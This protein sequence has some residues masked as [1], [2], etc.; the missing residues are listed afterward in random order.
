MVDATRAVVVF[1]G[2]A[3]L[4]TPPISARSTGI[5]GR[6]E[7]VETP[8]GLGGAIDVAVDVTA[9]TTGNR[10]RDEWFAALDPFGATRFPVAAYRSTRVEWNDGRGRVEGTLTLRGVTRPVPLTASYVL[11]RGGGHMLVRAS[12]I[13]DRSVFGVSFDAWG[14]GKRVP[15]LMRL[16]IDVDV[17]LAG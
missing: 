3:S 2:K 1:S 12:A 17:V 8:H 10:A 11:A 7:V 5:E 16:A 13:F 6:V 14:A 15:R 9:M 4:L